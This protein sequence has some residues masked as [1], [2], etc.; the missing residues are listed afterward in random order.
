MTDVSNQEAR[1]ISALR[2][3]RAALNWTQKELADASGIAQPSIARIETGS[4]K[5]RT[6]TL[7]KLKDVFEK[8][9]TRI[10]DN[11]P[12]GGYTI[13]IIGSLNSQEPDHG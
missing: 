7:F 10:I 12:T 8:A 5:P 6:S 3:A 4:A 1:N 2:A 11:D 13:K 9:G